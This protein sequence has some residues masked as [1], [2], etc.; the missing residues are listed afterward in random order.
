MQD[1]AHIIVNGE[2]ILVLRRYHKLGVSLKLRKSGRP[3]RE[4]SD[5]G[6]FIE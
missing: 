4:C 5:E 1:A 3:G 2:I 6:V